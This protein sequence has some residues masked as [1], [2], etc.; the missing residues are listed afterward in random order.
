MKKAPK[1]DFCSGRKTRERKGA[2]YDRSSGEH[3]ALR[4][5][6]RA[7]TG[8]PGWRVDDGGAH[9]RGAR[10]RAP[11][12][13]PARR[14]ALVLGCPSWLGGCAGTPSSRALRRILSSTSV[15]FRQK[16]TRYPLASSQR[17]STS[18][19]APERMCPICGGA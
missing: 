6:G 8:L 9:R 5:A 4:A 19:H 2:A 10:H 16:V 13:V 7:R 18:K 15:T 14:P 11:F 17:I 12:A 3:N 1:P